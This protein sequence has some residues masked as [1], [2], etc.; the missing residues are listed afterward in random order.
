[1]GDRRAVAAGAALLFAL[2]TALVALRVAPLLR[3]DEALS[4][5]ARSNADRRP[6]MSAITHTADTVVLLT[7]FAVVMAGLLVRR[8]VRPALFVLATAATATAVRISVL[9]AVHRPR[10][11]GPLT[12]VSSFAYPSGHST[13]STVAAGVLIVVGRP[14]LPAG[15]PRAVLIAVAGAWAVLVG[16]SRV[17]LLAHWP[18]D[19]L[20][21]WLLAV[22]VLTA[23]ALAFGLFRLRP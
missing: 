23:A 20:G 6:V 18:S 16:V 7:L 1:M 14:L 13:S 8:A 19:V 3:L 5:A 17:A 11:L 22:S 2:L 12:E 10:P 9:H 21:G 4:A 15:W